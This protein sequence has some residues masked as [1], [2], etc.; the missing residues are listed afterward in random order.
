ME[1]IF[2]KEALYSEDRH[3]TR[4]HMNLLQKT[5]ENFRVSDPSQD[6]KYNG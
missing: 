3:T 6:I 5:Y 2:T 1:W 4:S